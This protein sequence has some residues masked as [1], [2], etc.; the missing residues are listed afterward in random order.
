MQGFANTSLGPEGGSEGTY[1]TPQPRPHPLV[2]FSHV[3][4]GI[5]LF[6]PRN[7]RER[8]CT[9]GKL[10]ATLSLYCVPQPQA[11]TGVSSHSKAGWFL[12]TVKLSDLRTQHSESHTRTQKPAISCRAQWSKTITGEAPIAPYNRPGPRLIASPQR[13]GSRLIARL[14]HPGSY[15]LTAGLTD[16]PWPYFPL[17]P[18]TLLHPA[19]GTTRCMGSWEE[20]R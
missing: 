19:C 11:R 16:L 4:P 10:A 17:G 18:L 9:V 12:G 7:T 2:Y 20:S 1:Q 6:Y 13:P 8:C 14:L 3:Q 5:R 15:V